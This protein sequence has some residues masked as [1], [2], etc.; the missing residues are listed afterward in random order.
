MF[1]FVLSTNGIRYFRSLLEGTSDDS[2]TNEDTVDKC[3]LNETVNKLN[4]VN[5]SRTYRI[6][7]PTNK[8]HLRTNS[9]HP[10]IND[11]SKKEKG[12]YVS[13]SNDDDNEADNSKRF[14]E[15]IKAPLRMK[16]ALNSAN[17]MSAKVGFHST[18]RMYY[19]SSNHIA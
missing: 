18:N 1:R 3:Q 9:N 16:R 13:F 2:N 7:S 14:T 17:A 19:L 12:F 5:G 4:I 15:R 6:P 8:A 10:F 11:D